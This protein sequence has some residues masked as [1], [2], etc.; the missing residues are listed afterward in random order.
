VTPA[1]ITLL[2]SLCQDEIVTFMPDDKTAAAQTTVARG[3]FLLTSSSTQPAFCISRR[4]SIIA[5][6]LRPL[7]S[8]ARGRGAVH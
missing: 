2:R 8:E 3:G 7:R 1:E 6:Y 4:L 5:S